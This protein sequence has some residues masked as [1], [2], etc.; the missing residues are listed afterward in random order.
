M[1]ILHIESGRH[2]YG[3]ALQVYYLLRGLASEDCRNVLVC[4][5]QGRIADVSEPYATVY[6]VPLAGDLDPRLL[7]HLN[8]IARQEQPDLIHVHS[9]RGADIWGALAAVRVRVPAIIT[10]RVDNPEIP[11]LARL[12]YRFYDRVITISEGIRNVLLQEGVPSGKIVCVHS[13]VDSDR[14]SKACDRSWFQREFGLDA[15]IKAVGMVAQF[16]D[17]KGHRYLFEAVPKILTRFPDTMFLL[18]GRG[19]RENELKKL[20]SEQGISAHLRFAGFRDDLDRIFPCLDLL[21]HPALMEGLGVS[22]L[23]AAAAGVPMVATNVGGIPEIVRDG[24]NG[25]LIEPA[26]EQVLA[27]RVIDI[28]QNQE[29]ARRFA[30]ESLRIIK[31][32]FSIGSMVR[33]NLSVY[34]ELIYG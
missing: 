7:S 8:R 30:A 4:P 20:A 1:K 32:E 21:V 29:T 3:G 15:G 14:Y 6:A 11:V 28:L 2:L 16:I 24:I 22:L 5:S 19:P 27:D 18:F 25:Y 12:K 17:R 23:Q 31:S 34:K 9:R 10:R 26:D 13:A 33:G